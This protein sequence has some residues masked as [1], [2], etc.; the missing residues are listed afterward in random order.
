MRQR[1][2]DAGSFQRRQNRKTPARRLTQREIL[3]AVLLRAAREERGD[4]A[5]SRLPM[6]A[7]GWMTLGELA[8][9]TRFGEASISAQLRHLR[10][11]GCGEFVVEKRRRETAGMARPEQAGALWEYRVWR[12][13]R[14]KRKKR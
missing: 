12:E 1:S 4:A 9:A 13:R 14:R 3:C 2:A 11:P 10:K 5:R 6:Q 8:G 7:R